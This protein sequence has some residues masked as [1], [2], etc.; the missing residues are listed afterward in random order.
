MSLPRFGVRFTDDPTHD[1]EYVQTLYDNENAAVK[2]G[3]LF[4]NEPAEELYYVG[5][6]GVARTVNGTTP[7]SFT[8]IDFSGIREFANDAAAAAATPAVPVGGLYHTAGVL[9]VRRV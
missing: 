8:R 2:R 9:K 1:Q 5:S 6:D 4:L 7:V 3:E